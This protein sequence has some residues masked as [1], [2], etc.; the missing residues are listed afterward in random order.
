MTFVKFSYTPGVSGEHTSGTPPTYFHLDR[1]IIFRPFQ[2]A[3]GK[4]PFI[5]QSEN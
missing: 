2:G 4:K 5:L 1:C 3:A